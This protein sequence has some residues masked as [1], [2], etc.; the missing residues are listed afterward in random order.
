M[1][2]VPMKTHPRRL[3]AAL[4]IA[5]L[6]WP[7]AAQESQTFGAEDAARLREHIAEL[8]ARVAALEAAEDGLRPGG[9]AIARVALM[10]D[11]AMTRLTE[12]MRELKRGGG[13]EE[14]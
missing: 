11:R 4:V 9:K 12:M 2:G 1:L 3:A 13:S 7:A 8:E 5:A 6:A 14:L 10:A